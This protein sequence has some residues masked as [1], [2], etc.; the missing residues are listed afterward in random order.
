VVDIATRLRVGQRE[1]HGSIAGR[2]KKFLSCLQ[3]PNRL[4]CPLTLMFDENEGTF[5]EDKTPG[6]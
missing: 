1:D 4:W 6:P 3:R 2:G 5:L